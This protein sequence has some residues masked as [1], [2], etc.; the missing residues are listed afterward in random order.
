VGR[1]LIQRDEAACP[2]WR[3]ASLARMTVCLLVR[4]R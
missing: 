2:Y 4:Q 1:D 3:V